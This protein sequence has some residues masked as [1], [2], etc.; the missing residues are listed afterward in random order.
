MVIAIA[1]VAATYRYALPVLVEV[2]VAVTP[3][4][5]PVALSQATLASLDKAVFAE[6]GLEKSKQDE[7][8]AKFRA[9]AALSPRGAEGYTLNFRK[10]GRIGPNAFALPDGTLVI[11]D[12]LISLANGKDDAILG[13]LAHEIGHVEEQHSLR[14][15]YR[16]A[17]VAGL[18]ML[19][20][21]DLGSATEDIIVQGSALLTL[22]YSREF[23]RSADAFSVDLMR[24]AGHDPKA[25]ATFFEILMEK[26]GDADMG[27][28]STHPA[29]PER[30]RTVKR[31]AGEK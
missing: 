18:A 15:L 23:E 31:L 16:A 8:L 12:E 17:G 10:G 6:S 22:S 29:T 25:I 3:Q 13:V 21:G 24:R 9:L 4:A 2:A 26:Y 20:A 5:V 19:I 28:L 30:I 1:L 7:L 27:I 11:T 14:Q